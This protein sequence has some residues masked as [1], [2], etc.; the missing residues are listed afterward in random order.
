MNVSG[1][2]PIAA[3]GIGLHDPAKQTPQHTPAAPASTA[4]KGSPAHSSA[5]KTPWQPAPPLHP[6]VQ[7]VIDVDRALL[8][9]R[10]V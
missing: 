7:D 8:T 2:N 4:E 5:G 3:A 10:S 9:L 6:T 1:L